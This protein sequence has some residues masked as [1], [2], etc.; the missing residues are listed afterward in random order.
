MIF[1]LLIFQSP[2]KIDFEGFP[3]DDTYVTD[4]TKL[5]TIR[6]ILD[7]LSKNLDMVIT[8]FIVYVS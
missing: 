3:S 1:F 7:E 4:N 2:N 5:T 6:S 8:I